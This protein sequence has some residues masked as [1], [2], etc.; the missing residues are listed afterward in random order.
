[1]RKLAGAGR[2][3]D[4]RIDRAALALE[5]ITERVGQALS[6]GFLSVDHTGDL[7]TF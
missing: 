6:V 2:V 7:I 5:V 4:E 3:G 1:M